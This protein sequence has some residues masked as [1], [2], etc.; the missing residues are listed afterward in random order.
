M[1]AGFRKFALFDVLHPCSI[2][3]DGNIVLFL[4]RDR[5]GMTANAAVLVYN[6]AVAQF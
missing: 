2:Y 4:A 6:E 5:A 1:A 3:A